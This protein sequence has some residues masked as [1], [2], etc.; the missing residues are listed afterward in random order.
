M[1][2]FRFE[3]E[4]YGFELLMDLH[5]FEGN[6]NVAFE[7][8][9]HITDFF[10]VLIFESGKGQIDLNGHSHCIEPFTFFFISPHQKKSCH[11]DAST[12]KGFHLVFQNDF[13]S[14]FF[15]DTLFVYRLQYFYN[16]IHPQFLQ[17]EKDEY[18]RIKYI[19]DEIVLEIQH[20]QSD[21]YHII[22]SLLYFALT[23]LNRL[24]SKTYHLLHETQADSIAY[25]FKELLEKD[26]RTK[27]SVD[28][29]CQELLVSRHKLNKLVKNTFGNTSKELIQARL[30]QEIKMELR[31]SQQTISEIA[32]TMN[33]SE[34][35]NLTRFFHRLE[36]ISPSVYREKYQNDRTSL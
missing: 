29:Y 2:V 15:N 28:E 30:L 12:L 35:N 3:K 34:P 7:P 31:Y 27:H 11:I 6:P 18:K 13:L 16:S 25:Q 26:I 9:P 5:R 14:D 23:K 21:S 17:L 1:R 10:E 32:Y 8:T 33:F 19:L 20:F 22:R 24:Y 36:G 4:K